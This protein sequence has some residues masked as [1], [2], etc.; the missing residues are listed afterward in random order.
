MPLLVS[1]FGLGSTTGKLPVVGQA[2]S[3]TE[4]GCSDLT[5]SVVFGSSSL[6]AFD[7]VISSR[8]KT[9]APVSRTV[10]NREPNYAHRQFAW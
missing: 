2:V 4:E 5:P 9:T 6:D 10:V 1:C 8:V 7:F 3:D